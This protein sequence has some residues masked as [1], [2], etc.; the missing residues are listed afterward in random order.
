MRVYSVARGPQSLERV[1]RVL[2]ADE[3]HILPLVTSYKRFFFRTGL[4]GHEFNAVADFQSRGASVLLTPL[5]HADAYRNRSDHT[6]LRN[7]SVYRILFCH[8]EL[9]YVNSF[10]FLMQIRNGT[11]RHS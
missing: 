5:E 6:C 10:F 4:V 8:S 9:Q 1:S 2:S 3:A 11:H 7:D